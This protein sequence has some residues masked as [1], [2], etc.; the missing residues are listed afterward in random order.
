MAPTRIFCTALLSLVFLVSRPKDCF[1]RSMADMPS[2]ILVTSAVAAGVGGAAWA[3]GPPQS[4]PRA[5]RSERPSPVT[6]SAIPPA[7]K[8]WLLAVECLQSAP[9]AAP[10]RRGAFPTASAKTR[11]ATSPDHHSVRAVP[12]SKT[13][14]CGAQRVSL[15]GDASRRPHFS[16]A[17]RP[18]ERIRC[19]DPCCCPVTWLGAWIYRAPGSRGRRA[20]G[21]TDAAG[22]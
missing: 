11:R 5:L 13:R 4:W 15:T 16:S 19:R 9:P 22:R 14:Q 1:T 8:V 21:A 17:S 2:A 3:L 7:A 18:D 6:R 12:C 20:L 10:A